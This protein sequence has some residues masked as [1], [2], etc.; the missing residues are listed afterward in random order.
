[1]LS[2][3][4]T[5]NMKYALAIAISSWDAQRDTKQ[6]YGKCAWP[7]TVA[8][9]RVFP[10]L[11]HL[12]LALQAHDILEKIGF[13]KPGVYGDIIEKMLGGFPT[14]QCW[15]LCDSRDMLAR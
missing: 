14:Q 13:L 7:L 10:A 5:G 3:N 8:I 11:R 12:A 6:P 15:V 2:R 4:R 1:M 9:K